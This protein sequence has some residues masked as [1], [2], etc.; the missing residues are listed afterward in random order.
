M[1]DTGKM[2][3][4]EE[5]E[6]LNN[7]I[8]IIKNIVEDWLKDKKILSIY[9]GA[10]MLRKQ[11]KDVPVN[12]GNLHIQT[13]VGT[14]TSKLQEELSLIAS[15]EDILRLRK[16]FNATPVSDLLEKANKFVLLYNA[17]EDCL[18]N[19]KSLV[20]KLDVIN[21]HKNIIFI[22]ESKSIIEKTEDDIH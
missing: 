18:P 3:S 1:I 9:T 17:V 13:K 10:R 22:E 7:T 4:L 16:K 12:D 8:P 21:E 2:F 14:E 19:L 6:N 11:M 15:P 5:F 20:R